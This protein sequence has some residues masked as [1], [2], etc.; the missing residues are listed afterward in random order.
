MGAFVLVNVLAPIVVGEFYPFT[1]SPMFCDEPQVYCEY[2]LY[3][4]SGESLPLKEF[5]LQRN[6]DGNPPG[7]GVGIKPAPTLDH[8]GHVPDERQLRRHLEAQLAKHPEL[9]SV[10]VVQKVIGAIDMQRVGVIEERTLEFV[11]HRGSS[12]Q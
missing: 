6:Y 7:L 8:F 3:D 4:S 1:V 10:R 12:G 11:V 2:E 5:E 9:D